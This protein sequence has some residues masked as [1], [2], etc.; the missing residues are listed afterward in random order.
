[1]II[2]FTEDVLLEFTESY[3]EETDVAET[4]DEYFKKGETLEGDIVGEHP[5][6]IS[7]QAADGSVCYGIPRDCFEEVKGG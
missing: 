4:T 5:K 1:M 6:T 7:L 3:D 2:K